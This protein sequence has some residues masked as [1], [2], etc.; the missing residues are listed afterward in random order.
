MTNDVKDSAT[1][2]PAHAFLMKEFELLRTSVDN[3]VGE[4]RTLDRWVLVTTAAVWTWILTK[5][6]AML[7]SAAS[8]ASSAATE[9]AAATPPPDVVLFVPLFIVAVFF[10][11]TLAIND[12]LDLTNEYLRVHVE[13]QIGPERPND[14]KFGFETYFYKKRKSTTNSATRVRMARIRAW[15]YGYY[16]VLIIAYLV[17]AIWGLGIFR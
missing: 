16:A 13:A 11:K 1:V 6:P 12:T 3:A 15:S 5:H 8:A 10:L 14:G 17:M 7:L 2:D 4:L 9:T